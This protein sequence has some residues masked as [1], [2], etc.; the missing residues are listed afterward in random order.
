MILKFISSLALCPKLYIT[1]EYQSAL[2][3]VECLHIIFPRVNEVT[4]TPENLRVVTNK[5]R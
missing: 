5:I 4:T 2:R 1:I 3:F